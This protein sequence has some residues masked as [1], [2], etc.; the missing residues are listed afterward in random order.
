MS[1]ETDTRNK[2]NEIMEAMEDLLLYKNRLYGNSALNPKQI[3]YKGDAVNS[4][5]IRLDDKLGRIMANTDE[6]PRINDVAD[7]IGY[8]TLLLISMGVDKA[9]IDNLRD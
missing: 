6:N 8:C 3:F 2:I 4:I 7:I 9:D 1:N 5:L